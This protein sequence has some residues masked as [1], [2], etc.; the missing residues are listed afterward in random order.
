MRNLGDMG[1]VE[2]FDGEKNRENIQMWESMHG[3]NLFHILYYV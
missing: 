3:F 2:E 1:E